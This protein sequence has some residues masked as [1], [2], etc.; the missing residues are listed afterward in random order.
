DS[1]R[2]A[3]VSQTCA[4]VRVAVPTQSLR[5]RSKWDGAP[6]APGAT[7]AAAPR[8]AADAVPTVPSAST[9]VTATLH[10]T[11][12]APGLRNSA[13]DLIAPPCGRTSRSG[14]K[15]KSPLPAPESP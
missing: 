12:T 4:G 8:P 13:T 6:G 11:S 15:G 5:A 14:T 2:P 10:V 9:V 1:A 7:S 3:R